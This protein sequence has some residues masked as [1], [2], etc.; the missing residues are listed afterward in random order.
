MNEKPAKSGAVKTDETGVKT[1]R[2]GAA[3]TEG[4]DVRPAKSD[5]ARTEG[6]DVRPAKSDA[7]RT[8]GADVRPVKSGSVK[9]AGAAAEPAKSGSVKY[10]EAGAKPAKSGTVKSAGSG[11]VRKKASGKKKQKKTLKISRRTVITGAAVFGAVL[12]A[13][14]LFAVL[15]VQRAQAV[16]IPK[17]YSNHDMVYN[18]K[19]EIALDTTRAF[20]YGLCVSSDDVGNEAIVLREGESAALMSLDNREVLFSK[21]MHERIYPA[22][23]T[24]IMTAILTLKYGNMDEVVTVIWRDLELEAG[25]QVVGFRIGDRVTVRELLHGLLVHSGNDA[26]MVLARYIGGGSV[27]TF[28]D[29]MNQELVEIGATNSHFTNP[30]GLHDTDHYTTVYDIYLM[31]NE[32]ITYT[33]FRSI[34]QLGKY[35]L[36]YTDSDENPKAIN[37]DS[38]DE[39]LTGETRPP[40]DVVVLGGKTGTT[41]AAGHCLAIMSQNAFGQ[42]FISIIMGAQNSSDLYEDMNILLSQIN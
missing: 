14:I 2:S 7:A 20:A 11:A 39:Y 13:V 18:S 8:E 29:L 17:I 35:E 30:T 12:C 1:V 5:A 27:E 34:M 31:L 24:K 6:A 10:E 15:S 9:T 22:S 25:S 16:S 23:I 4:A 41:D 32:A 38:T 19:E 21:N 36:D 3:K 33:D 28:V 40:K 37:L 42:P 26:A